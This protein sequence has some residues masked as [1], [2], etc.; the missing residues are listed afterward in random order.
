MTQRVFRVR[1]GNSDYTDDFGFRGKGTIT[2]DS[3]CLTY[4][5]KKPW[6]GRLR[7]LT[8]IVILS[9]AIA[10]S[11]LIGGTDY[12]ALG[13][14]VGLIAGGIVIWLFCKSANS[15]SIPLSAI[16]AVKTQGTS[17][18]ITVPNGESQNSLVGVFDLRKSKLLDEAFLLLRQLQSTQNLPISFGTIPPEP[19]AAQGVW[20]WIGFLI[21]GM[22]GFWTDPPPP[23]D[24]TTPESRAI[25]CL[26]SSLIVIFISCWWYSQSKILPRKGT[27]SRFFGY[28][29][30][31]IVSISLNSAVVILDMP[32]VK[33]GSVPRPYLVP[34]TV[35]MTFCL[36]C[37][38]F[39][40][41]AICAAFF[42]VFQR[43]RFPK[44]PLESEFQHE[45]NA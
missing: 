31:G 15:L 16:S 34:F 18:F 44:A 7:A 13:I 17:V 43:R 36:V 42:L 8:Y 38:V 29:L 39:S 28:L 35:A 41:L 2:I 33:K 12:I 5:G 1:F 4:T 3:D 19:W 25:C 27:A 37:F 22:V 40:S 14:I 26:L 45:L 11:V 32:Y 21:I 10:A 6:S 9:I 23:L 20:W 30:F 24:T